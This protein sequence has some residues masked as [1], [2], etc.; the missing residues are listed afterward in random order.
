MGMLSARLA[1]GTPH[2][3]LKDIS[4][5]GFAIEGACPFRPGNRHDFAF[6]THAGRVIP[7]TAEVVMSRAL[8]GPRTTYQTGFRFIGTDIATVEAIE[9][10]IDAVTSPL[11]FL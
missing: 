7:M 9:S 6:T 4:L 8:S 2:V 1:A 5:D 3:V 10:L 11:E